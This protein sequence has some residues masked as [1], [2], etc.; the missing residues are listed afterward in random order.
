MSY[1]TEYSFNSESFPEI[2]A[3]D[4]TAD[5]VLKA[6]H[7]PQ[8]PWLYGLDTAPSS[9]QFFESGNELIL[10]PFT[11]WG[12]VQSF[13]FSVLLCGTIAPVYFEINSSSVK[14]ANLLIS[15]LNPLSGIALWSTILL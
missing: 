11:S 15:K 2:Y 10:L 14:S 3:R 8:L 9:N 6:Q 5:A 12:T 13:I 7:P 4:S 1:W